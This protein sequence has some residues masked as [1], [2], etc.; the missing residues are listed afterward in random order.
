MT[1][2][3]RKSITLTTL[4]PSSPDSHLCAQIQHRACV[5]VCAWFSFLLAFLEC[6]VMAFTCGKNSHSRN[7]WEVFVS[8]TEGK[9][10]HT[11]KANSL[12]V[13]GRWC[14]ARQCEHI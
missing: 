3:E 2:F 6:H 7:F 13:N 5:C 1:F 12:S 4:H 10:M 14:G 11:P 8:P 9:E